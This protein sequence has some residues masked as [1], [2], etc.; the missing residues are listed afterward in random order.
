MA[1]ALSQSTTG[2]P[3]GLISNDTSNM[4]MGSNGIDQFSYLGT[5][6][7]RIADLSAGDSFSLSALSGTAA[8]Y[9]V[10]G[11]TVTV[12]VG[13]QTFTLMGVDDG[14][15]TTLNFSG[16]TSL[17]LA[18]SGSTYT[19]TPLGGTAV[20]LSGTNQTIAA[21]DGTVSF[22]LTAGATA[23]AEGGSAT[24]AL[25][26]SGAANP[27]TSHTVKLAETFNNGAGTADV[28]T[29]QVTGTGV[30]Y[31]ATTGVVTL[32][33]GTKAATITQAFKTDALTPETGES[34]TLTLSDATGGAQVSTT[35][36][37]ATTAIT[38]VPPAA[39]TFALAQDKTAVLEGNT[40]TFT[41][42]VASGAVSTPTTLTY[43]IIG[44]NIGGVA[45]VATPGIDF[46]PASGTLDFAVGETSKQVV[47]TAVSD[48]VM[49]SLEGMK[50]SLL[51]G[52]VLIDNK[53]VQITD[54]PN[55]GQTFT[56]T[57]S[58][59]TF[60]G[61]AGADT[62][63]GTYV[64]GA[65]TGT[66]LT[67]GDNLTGG[68][69]IDTLNVNVSGA[70]TAGAT[71]SSFTLNGIEKVLF[72]N[73]DTGAD[74]WDHTVNMATA[75]GVTTV[76]LSGSA[77][78]G[79]TTF[80]NL[81]NVVD[82]QMKGGA[83]LSVQYATSLL[84]GT[85]DSVKLAVD[86]VGTSAASA[87]FETYASTTTGIAETLNIAST[88]GAS[89]LTLDTDN[90]HKTIS[91]TGSANLSITK[92]LDTTVTK[93]D[94][95]I[96]AG[97]LKT[98]LG[99]SD[100]NV[101]GGLGND[102]INAVATLTAF[103]TLSGG[104]G[105]DTLALSDADTLTSATGAR[106]SGFEYLEAT[107][108]DTTSFDLSF[109]SGVTKVITTHASN[110]A[111]IV[112]NL[113]AT[114]GLQINAG[115]DNN[116][117]LTATLA[118]N[119]AADTANVTI[120]A[121][122]A[123][124][125]TGIAF[126]TLLLANH[127]II[128]ITSTGGTTTATNS[129]A[130][131]TGAAAT[132][133]TVAGDRDLTLTAFTPSGSSLKT[134]DASTFS[135]KLNMVAAL[136]GTNTTISGGSSNDT[137]TGG[138]GNDSIVGNAGNDTISLV[139]NGN[140]TVDGGAGN[141]SI[142]GGS[143]N[144]VVTAGDGNDN[145]VGATGDDNLN[146]G[147]GDDIFTLT[148]TDI[149]ATDTINGGDGIDVISTTDTTVN[150]NSTATSGITNVERLQLV[151]IGATTVT[152][153][154]T[155]IG[156]FNNNVTI[157]AGTDQSHI[158]DASGVLSSVSQVNF[159]GAGGTEIYK[160]GNGKDNVNMGAG[161]DTVTV[162][163]VVYLSANDTIAGGA[164]TGDTLNI[165]EQV[166]S[167][168]TISAAQIANLS[169][170]ETISFDTNTT[171]TGTGN[172]VF[173]LTDTFL[174]AN[175]NAGALTVS[176]GSQ[177]A[178]SDTGTLKVDASA[179]S[180]AYALSLAGASGADTLIGGAGNDVISGGLGLDS[181]TGGLGN[182]IF[183][184]SDKLLI[185]VITDFNFGTSTTTVDSI[186]LDASD[187]IGHVTLSLALDTG[188]DTV[189]KGS[190]VSVAATTDVLVVTDVTYANAAA[191]D[192]A[193]EAINVVTMTNDFLVVY[194]DSLGTV[195]VAYADVTTA[196]LATGGDEVTTTDLAQ[197]SGVTIT[198]IASLIDLGDFSIVE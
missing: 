156:A 93:V 79:D 155:G 118:T 25:N 13:T 148:W 16:G 7:L 194:Q 35:A 47:V 89:Y 195:R 61:A 138:T 180:S 11:N 58:A 21:S 159:T 53:T 166:A 67:S 78:L 123:T 114:T 15:S 4:L 95:G 90:D 188:V 125:A 175:N 72:S 150:L 97:A 69:G 50:F 133:V 59:D 144:D 107:A 193:L 172:Y 37:T 101:L 190:A 173:N 80:N 23:I 192:T 146:A 81:A 73:F 196:A 131:V 26:L 46:T 168:M 169:G 147:A 109:L 121:A 136:T 96:F 143:G 181:M 105:N 142:T 34:V 129:I 45:T 179:V 2:G 140:N 28:D 163:T 87:D 116:E 135:G 56:L 30:S 128:N 71:I 120:G 153:N 52:S 112:S 185:D 187:M 132:K 3:L 171:T 198:G 162:S 165:A 134:L 27:A 164:G 76:G 66:T 10:S 100:I 94:A 74:T 178:E 176:R 119:T 111:V 174:T 33:A 62:F 160:V 1:I 158:I 42:S 98:T 157:L 177:A 191:L 20:T 6:S 65:G 75:T 60:T 44:D 161:N 86:A 63:N 31:N 39:P 8:Q 184:L 182:D 9:K 106:V 197:L 88:G 12:T 139:A 83:D 5:G 14:A 24:W 189:T 124:D 103:D 152:I 141:D 149:T 167:A 145:L 183:V 54:D 57:G 115:V 22:G 18:R 110:D 126:G 40:V 84:T 186:K 48:S 17:T 151:K 29:L 117:S 43:S 51:N 64:D 127:E 68:N 32:A 36:A 108:G 55:V 77:A 154:D 104:A 41:V 102:Y 85:T 137:L 130:A 92:T 170:F 19:A 38:D 70:L 122:N 99:V 113:G 91:V 82:A 49:E